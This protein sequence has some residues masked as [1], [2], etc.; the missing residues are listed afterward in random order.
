MGKLRIADWEYKGRKVYVRE[1]NGIV[2]Q[3]Q[4]IDLPELQ[5]TAMVTVSIDTRTGECRGWIYERDSMK[6]ILRHTPD[7]SVLTPKEFYA[8]KSR[9][10]RY[11]GVHED[12]NFWQ[13][14]GL[15]LEQHTTYE[16]LLSNGRK[17]PKWS[18]KDTFKRLQGSMVR[19]FL[20]EN[21]DTAIRVA[22]FEKRK[23]EKKENYR[24]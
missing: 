24:E 22:E 23:N 18:R 3:T 7:G 1:I 14:G 13:R 20:E 12:D 19:F 16:N 15:I 10:S 6:S 8:L 2:E 5:T 4:H 17:T 21:E 9:Y 11:A